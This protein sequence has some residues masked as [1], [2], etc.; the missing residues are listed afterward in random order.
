M[1]AAVLV[2]ACA[3]PSLAVATGRGSL[4]GHAAATDRYGC[5]SFK[6]PLLIPRVRVRVVR[7]SVACSTARSVMHW[8]YTSHEG[9]F[10]RHHD[11]WTTYGPQTCDAWATKGG[12]KITGN[13]GPG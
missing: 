3:L 7:G 5:G 4:P 10:I 9:S 2:L 1:L 13:C 11:G 12:K 6:V 8:T